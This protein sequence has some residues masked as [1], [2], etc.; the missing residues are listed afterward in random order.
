MFYW[1][2]PNDAPKNF[3]SDD[4]KWV[5]IWN[6][7]FM[8]YNKKPDGTFEPLKQKNVDT[9][10]GLERLVAILHGKPS[11]YETELFAPAMEKIKS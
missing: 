3:D 1:T 7:V 10:L 5:E 6:D 2:P 11:H 8:Q 4:G 9:G